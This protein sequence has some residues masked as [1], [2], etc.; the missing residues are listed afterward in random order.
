MAKNGKDKSGKKGKKDKSPQ[1]ED[2][3][4]RDPAQPELRQV[5]PSQEPI[6]E[7]QNENWAFGDIVREPNHD[8]GQ[9]Q[10]R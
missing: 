5:R 8:D 7:E 1:P 6:P 2:E 3:A 10:A 4:P 9:G